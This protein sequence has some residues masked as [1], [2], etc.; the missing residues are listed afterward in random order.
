MYEKLLT[1]LHKFSKP[2]NPRGLYYELSHN[3]YYVIM[4]AKRRLY[5]DLNLMSGV[6]LHK[7]DTIKDAH[8]KSH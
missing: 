8:A 5:N 3:V 6:R 7:A 1:A 2:K 4:M